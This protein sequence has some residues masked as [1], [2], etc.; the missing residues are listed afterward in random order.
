MK[1]GVLGVL[2]V[3]ALEPSFHATFDVMAVG[4]AFAHV[5]SL[6]LD[7]PVVVGRKLLE[8]LADV[9]DAFD[10]DANL[11]LEDER[12]DGS[13]FPDDDRNARPEV[14]GCFV[15]VVDAK[16]FAPCSAAFVSAV[17]IPNKS[18]VGFSLADEIV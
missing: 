5:L 1:N 14:E 8:C 13:L 15:R 7:V 18:E 17:A 3:K 9:A 2:K 16:V 10:G 11:L 12:R 4:E 6:L